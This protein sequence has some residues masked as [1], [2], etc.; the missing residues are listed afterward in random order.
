M[1]RVAG[2]I[3]KAVH[4]S[5]E[6]RVRG[7]DDKDP[8]HQDCCLDLPLDV[9]R[10]MD[11]RVAPWS[12]PACAPP[13]ALRIRPANARTSGADVSRSDVRS[14]EGLGPCRRHRIATRARICSTDF[15]TYACGGFEDSAKIAKYSDE[16]YLSPPPHR[17]GE[18]VR[19]ASTHRYLSFDP[20]TEHIAS[21]MRLILRSDKGKAGVLY[22]ACFDLPSAACLPPACSPTHSR[23]A[24]H[25][26]ASTA[27]D[28]EARRGPA[29]VLSAGPT[30]RL[31]FRRRRGRAV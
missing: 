24:W 4:R 31:P 27:A 13:N 18:L 29:C 10:N 3:K 25:G 26:L 11:I 21:E 2:I 14:C 30:H 1:D 12:A 28:T 16:W 17:V 7:E 19:L 22:R 8:H 5:S 6:R 15:Y 9:L 20:V 23:M